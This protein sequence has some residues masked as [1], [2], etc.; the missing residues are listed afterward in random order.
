[1]KKH[2]FKIIIVI[3]LIVITVSLGRIS[4]DYASRGRLSWLNSKIADLND[5]I[6]YLEDV[7]YE[8]VD[9]NKD[10]EHRIKVL[11]DGIDFLEGITYGLEDENKDLEN[12]IKV[13]ERR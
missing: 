4:D 8:L 9:E 3:W 12:R 5:E 10:L 2:W 6:D 13:L 1:M 7:T 11:K